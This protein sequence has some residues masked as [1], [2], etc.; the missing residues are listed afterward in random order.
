VITPRLDSAKFFNFRHARAVRYDSSRRKAV[1]MTAA[2]QGKLADKSLGELIRE[3]GDAFDSGAL[4]LSRAP[5][6]IVIYFENGA[7]VFAVSNIR[8]HRLI[9]FLKR[10]GLAAEVIAKLPTT[11]TDDEVIAEAGLSPDQVGRLRA[12]QA[13]DIVRTALLWTEG[14]WEFD[15]RVRVAGQ[16][17]VQVETQRLLLE[18]ARLLPVAYIESRFANR[19]DLFETAERNGH[20]LNLSPSEAFVLSR[21]TAPISIN[22]LLALGGM[23]DEKTMRALYALTTAGLLRRATGAAPHISE[24]PDIGRTAGEQLEVVLARIETASD[25][26]ET[27][28]IDR[29]ASPDDVKNSYHTLARNYHPDRFHQSGVGVRTRI[30]SAFARVA[31][32][33]EVL[34]D[35]AER[36]TYDERLKRPG[37]QRASEHTSTPPMPKAKTRETG[38]EE[39]AEAS[40]QK[41]L[42][43]MRENQLH[44]AVRLF[45]EA[46][47]L[48]PR[49]ARYRAEYGR[50][51]INDPQT[52]RIAE[53]ELQ[54]AVAL[55]PAN[56]SYRVALAELYKA[57]GLRR[58]AEGELQRALMTDPKSD[59]AR[60]LLASLKN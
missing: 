20:S 26:Y 29:T 57:L 60:K 24:S 6:K 38:N 49:R 43:A 42:S 12:N 3:I 40:F 17:R 53:I 28:G 33:Y 13:A 18:S 25:Y 51:L 9:E 10:T 35:P 19:Q 7:T 21:V 14:Y 16:N 22:N 59:A 30:E 15:A 39:R 37:T 32:A 2:K 11:A 1:P 8:A 31:R 36:E 23:R 47:S 48:E 52:R 50:A 54:A 46:A 27:L 34:H 44:H 56:V 55:E 58:R 45:A 5:A 41:G 4:R